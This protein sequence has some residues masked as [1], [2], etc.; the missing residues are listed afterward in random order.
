MAAVAVACA[1]YWYVRERQRIEAPELESKVAQRETVTAVRCVQEAE[2]GRRWH[3][4]GTK[5]EQGECFAVT[6]NWRSQV[7]IKPVGPSPCRE[8]T[9]LAAAFT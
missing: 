8:D 5:G 1:G 2:L 4:A 9:E 6:V 3:C 7:T